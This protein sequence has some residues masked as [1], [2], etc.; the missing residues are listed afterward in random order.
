MQKDNPILVALGAAQKAFRA[1]DSPGALQACLKVLEYVPNH[2]M[3]HLMAGLLRQT[4]GEFDEAIRHLRFA[5]AHDPRDME[6][7]DA[8]GMCLLAKGRHA[9]ALPH[10]RQVVAGQPDNASARYNLG[11]C[12]LDLRNYAEAERVYEEHVQKHPGDAEAFNHLGLARLAKGNAGA[13]E[14]C[15]RTA[16]QLHPGEPLFHA[17]FAQSMAHQGRPAE[18]DA[19]YGKA[20]AQDPSSAGFRVQ[21]GWFLL[22]DGQHEKAE[23]RFREALQREPENESASGGIATALERRREVDVGLRVLRPFISAVHPHAKVA[24][25]YAT[26]CRRKAQPEQALPVV[27]RAIRPGVAKLEE[28]ALRF[29]EGDLL[30]AMGQVDAAFD[31]YQRAN[32]AQGKRYDADAHKAFVDA[33]IAVFTPELFASMPKPQADTSASVLV[34]GMPRSGSSLVEQILDTH[35]EIHGAGELDDL[36]TIASGIRHYVDGEGRYPHLVAQL[37]AE[38]VE[39]LSA[40]RMDSLRRTSNSPLVVDK[41]PHNF[42]H[43]GLAAI[44]TPNARVI[45]TV[46]DPVDTCLSCFFQHFGGS[47]FAFTNRLDALSSFFAQY[48]RLMKH[49]E[50]V[51]PL[52]MLTVRYEDLVAETETVSRQMLG[53]LGREWDASVLDFHKNERLV[54]TASYAQVRQPVYSSSVGKAERYR[55]RIGE[56][57]ALAQLSL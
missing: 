22:W 18:A 46:R 10:M 57:V 48:H 4:T 47:T 12:L 8:L 31:A 52:E 39:K 54:A 45:H 42:L 28:A 23:D 26:L 38:L 37:N 19:A 41:L 53:F 29:A 15:F 51:L 14:Q 43:L 33:L 13:A 35:P 7:R 27:R 2:P 1:G 56:L 11:R 5:V 32:E 49:W 44:V 50:A 3:A 6:A 36:P 20:I 16:I 30:D 34:C 24:V 17:N 21:H 9:E 55:H 40:A 25:S